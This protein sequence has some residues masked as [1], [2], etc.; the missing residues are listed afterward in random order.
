MEQR[1]KDIIR[2]NYRKLSEEIQESIV[3][4]CKDLWTAKIISKPMMEEI[5]EGNNTNRKRAMALLDLLP[6][7]GPYAFET[8]YKL[9]VAN[10]LHG[11]ADIL[12]PPSDEQSHFPKVDVNFDTS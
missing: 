12:K 9:A 1:H 6:T 11:A 5:L 3:L 10:E 8:F 4:L 7:R 2:R